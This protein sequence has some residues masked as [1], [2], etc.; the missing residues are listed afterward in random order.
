[1]DNNNKQKKMGFDAK[2]AHLENCSEIFN[3]S[4]GK[5]SAP[6]LCRHVGP[7]M[8][9]ILYDLDLLEIKP[10]GT[11]PIRPGDVIFFLPPGGEQPVVHRV[12][13]ISPEGIGTR[14]DNNDQDDPW[15][16]TPKDVLGRVVAVWRGQ[17]KRMVAGE[18]AG[19]LW[20]ALM[21]RRRRLLQNTSILLGPAYR[22]LACSGIIRSGLSAFLKPRLLVFQSGS[23]TNY[24]LLVGKR[25]VGRYNPSGR[26]WDIKRP[27][28]LC[29]DE[30]SLPPDPS[31]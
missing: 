21:R 3:K 6:A 19:R 23:C 28:K 16:I 12:L 10:Y 30:S 24:Q 7:S 9:P 1:M 20:G 15:H 29:V 4:S 26:R 11:S 8:N 17:R 31:D 5:R 13:R 25:V 18:G 2:E 22:S 14:G 27:F